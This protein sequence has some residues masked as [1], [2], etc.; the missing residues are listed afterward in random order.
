MNKLDSL[1]AGKKTIILLGASFSTG[2]LG[3][4]ALAWSSIKLVLQRWP[5]SELVC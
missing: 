2:N 3:V 1:A 5:E 4:S